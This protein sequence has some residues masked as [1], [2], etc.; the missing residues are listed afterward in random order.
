MKQVLLSMAIE[1]VE[2]KERNRGRQQVKKQLYG[3]NKAGKKKSQRTLSIA[4]AYLP[5]ELLPKG[6]DINC[7]LHS[8]DI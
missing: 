5:Q 2:L 4:Q 6:M 3:K 8:V 7:A 1:N